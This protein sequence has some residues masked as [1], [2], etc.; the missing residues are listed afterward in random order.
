MTFCVF[1]GVPVSKSD[2]TKEHVLPMWLLK[3][4][5]DPNRKIRIGFDSDT[6]DEIIRPASTF[7]FPACGAC[8]WSY[9]KRLE[10][11][12]KKIFKAVSQGRSISVAQSYRLLDWLDK[13]RIGMWLGY[14]MLQK[15]TR[16]LPKFHI[17]SRLGRKDRLAIISVDPSDPFVGLSFG[18]HDNDLFRKS[19]CGIYLRI[20]N[21]RILSLSFDF[22][23]RPETGLPTTTEMFLRPE[24]GDLFSSPLEVGNFELVQDWKLF[25]KI[26]G[27]IVAQPI[28]DTRLLEPGM[29]ANLYFGSRVLTHAKDSVRVRKDADFKRILPLQLIS[30]ADGIVRYYPNKRSRIRF[31]PSALHNDAAFMHH[32]YMFMLQRVLSLFPQRYEMADGS[33]QGSIEMTRDYC[34]CCYQ[35]MSRIEKMGLPIPPTDELIEDIQRFNRIVEE[36]DAFLRGSCTSQPGANVTARDLGGHQLSV[37]IE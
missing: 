9:G 7:H 22:L 4:T 20:N 28:V 12:A 34:E 16:F 30:N 1:C 17:N 32:L 18:G 10:T 13:V 27:I 3:A 36:R 33:K 29:A 25:S 24:S 31:Q 37:D 2:R 8:N 26:G 5:G 21:V 23:L 11:Q 15:E 19:Q 14:Y 6:G 35:I